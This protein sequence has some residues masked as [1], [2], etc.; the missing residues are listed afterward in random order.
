MAQI[1]VEA[2]WRD[3]ARTPRFFVMDAYAAFPLL[4]WL[5]HFRLWTFIMAVSFTSF[6]AALEYYGFTLRV[7]GRVVR[8]FLAG[9]RKLST[10]WW[11]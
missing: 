1:P 3:S 10:P 6:F 8:E 5:L 7:F 4:I 2:H 9:P 11:K